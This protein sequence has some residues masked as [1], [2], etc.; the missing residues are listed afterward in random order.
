M[1]V[2]EHPLATAVGVSVL[3]RGGNAADAAVATALALAVC[4]P[5]A[6]NLGGGGLALWVPANGDPRAL[7]F[8]ETA[9]HGARSEVYFDERGR[10]VPERLTQGALAVAVPGSPAGLFALFEEHG[11][12]RFTLE[13]LVQPAVR[14]ARRGFEVDAPLAYAL[15]RPAARAP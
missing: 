6:G 13:E 12:G 9:P 11:S 7:N 1:V 5:Q 8:R 2:S 14:L 10:A 4:Y 15:S 3:E